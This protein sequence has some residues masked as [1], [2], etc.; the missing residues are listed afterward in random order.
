VIFPET[1]SMPIC[2]LVKLINGGSMIPNW[3]A[4]PPGGCIKGVITN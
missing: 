2:S 4:Y 3:Q 1:K